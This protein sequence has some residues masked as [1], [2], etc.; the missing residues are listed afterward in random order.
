MNI[1]ISQTAGK[2]RAAATIL[3]NWLVKEMRIG[4]PWMS[5][6]IHG[7]DNWRKAIRR[8]LKEARIGI[9]CITAD[10]LAN[11]W[12]VYE[13]GAMDFSRIKVFPYVIDSTKFR[14]LPSPLSHLQGARAAD[15]EGTKSLVI[16]INNALGRPVS[17]EKLL[18]TFEFK[19][20][21]LKNNLENIHRSKDYE[22][23]IDDFITVILIMNE[24][25]K[26]LDFS[27][28]VAEFIESSQN[29]G[30]N[31]KKTVQSVFS[32]I[33]EHREDFIKENNY[34]K[35]NPALT[36]K[37]R[38]FFKRNFKKDNLQKIIIK[39]EP[40]LLSESKTEKEKEK[41]M[42]SLIQIELLEVFLHFHRMLAEGLRDDLFKD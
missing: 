39:L 20:E 19:W 11:Q 10:N 33:E 35:I 17:K 9:L 3:K 2:S 38:A 25:R 23:A 31:R 30:Y 4:D 32:A 7:G 27:T 40:I 15:K 37:V 42:L 14:N 24:F 34:N 36:R 41:E 1:F 26:S 13:A 16:K 29:Q 8:A 5:T 21:I 22:K 18:E 6:D 12:I 28:I